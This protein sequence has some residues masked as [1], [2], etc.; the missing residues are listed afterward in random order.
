MC[1][2]VVLWGRPWSMMTTTTLWWYWYCTYST[3]QYCDTLYLYQYWYCT[4]QYSMMTWSRW[5]WLVIQNSVW[6]SR[7]DIVLQFVYHILIIP[8]NSTYIRSTIIIL[9]YSN[10]EQ[11]VVLTYRYIIFNIFIILTETNYFNKIS[12]LTDKM[13]V[14]SVRRSSSWGQVIQ[15]ILILIFDDISTE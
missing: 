4:L 2:C 13:C 5:Q 8:F 1:V 9:W 12:N 10:T 15:H 14:L 11:Y 3:V 6:I 7:G